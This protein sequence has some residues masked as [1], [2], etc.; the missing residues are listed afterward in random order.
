MPMTPHVDVLR[1]M[2]TLGLRMKEE[3]SDKK[4]QSK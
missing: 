4:F 1:S 2:A 3:S